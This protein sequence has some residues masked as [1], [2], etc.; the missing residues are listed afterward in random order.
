MSGFGY[1]EHQFVDV[2]GFRVVD[3]TS[4]GSR[5]H[6]DLVWVGY[7]GMGGCW[8]RPEEA[9]ALS[10]AIA[11]VANGNLARRGLIG[12]GDAS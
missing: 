10:A 3:A 6:D 2:E 4:T 1:V 9:L 11:K 8:L 7:G 12:A 5:P